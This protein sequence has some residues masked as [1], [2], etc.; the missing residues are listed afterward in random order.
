M[1]YQL[2]TGQ[3]PFARHSAVASMIALATEEP[4]PVQSLNADI[5]DA[6]ARVIHALLAKA[7][8][9]RPQTAAEVEKILRALERGEHAPDAR[10]LTALPTAA[11]PQVVYVPIHVTAYEP[12]VSEF[13]NLGD[14]STEHAAAERT[15]KGPPAPRRPRARFP[16]WAVAVAVLAVA[17]GGT[18]FALRKPTEG[19]KQIPPDQKTDGRP[20]TPPPGPP[21][22]PHETRVFAQWVF[23]NGG[24]VEVSGG[25]LKSLVGAPPG[26]LVILGVSFNGTAYRLADKDVERL[27]ACPHLTKLYCSETALTDEGLAALAALPQAGQLDLL[28][29]SSPRATIAGVAHL[30]K[31]RGLTH[32]TVSRTP[33]T[34]GLKFVRELPDL[35]HFI[36]YSAKLTDEDLAAFR[37]TRLAGLNVPFNP[38]IT[39]AGLEHLLDCTGLG[40]LDVSDTSVAGKDAA[41]IAKLAKLNYLKASNLRWTDEDV[42]RL[43]PLKQMQELL[44]N[45]NLI[46]DAGF[47]RDLPELRKLN[48]S[49]TGIT[50]AALDTLATSKKLTALN[51]SGTKVTLAGVK[52]FQ[53]ALPNC[54]VTCDY[55]P[56]ADP[57]RLL[58]E[59]LISKGGAV[60]V[61]GTPK[62]VAQT[63]ELPAGPLRAHAAYLPRDKYA[64]TDTDL[65]RF[66]DTSLTWYALAGPHA[67][68]DDGLEKWSEFPGADKVQCFELINATVTA[69]GYAHLARFKALEAL[70]LMQSGI[71]DRGL[72][73]CRELPNLANLSL[74][75]TPVTDE[76]MKHLAGS[77]LQYLQLMQT[78]VGD[79][80]AEALATLSAL[81]VLE[82]RGTKLTDKGLALLPA[83]K[84]LKRLDVT[85][86]GV[87][88]DGAK[89]F[90]TALPTC[91]LVSDHAK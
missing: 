41:L 14:P 36:A 50:D 49:S 4:P 75:D 60:A 76:G 72:A 82:L 23:D 40:A 79:A 63:S 8:A 25:E 39:G 44:L 20:T 3:R 85:K 37:G 71:T 80:G 35:K 9:A 53:D 11:Q 15:E 58:A 89:A 48:L 69:K 86:T 47:V 87:T 30:A 6:L 73:V 2:T 67:V 66:R 5:P 51:V 10:E 1:L 43:R 21:K 19:A 45:G 70:H 59:W 18:V 57:D 68:T 83:C 64:L 7:P 78:A 61:H 29:V 32:L 54:K 16:V 12:I 17:I 28:A 13:A 24:T 81:E 90:R 46:A 38:S 42:A 33:L 74:Q 31:C 84:N 22:P 88:A 62:T 91:E 65:D 56:K 34:G 52:A 26:A 27:R 77:K 55:D